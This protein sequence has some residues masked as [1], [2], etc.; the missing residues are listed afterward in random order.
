MITVPV[1]GFELQDV[2][3]VALVSAL[4]TFAVAYFYV[5]KDFDSN[6]RFGTSARLGAYSGLGT[7]G[8]TKYGLRPGWA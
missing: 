7:W 2:I 8:V 5:L 6:V 1:L 3:A 4:I